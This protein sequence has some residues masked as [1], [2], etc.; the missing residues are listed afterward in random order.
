MVDDLTE[1]ARSVGLEVNANKTNWMSTNSTGQT[2]MVNGV[3]LGLGTDEIV[4]NKAGQMPKTN[5]KAYAM[6]PTCRSCAERDDSRPNQV[7]RRDSRSSKEE[8]EICEEDCGRRPGKMGS[9][10]SE[11]EARYQKAAGKTKNAK[12]TSRTST[13]LT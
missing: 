10:A 7:E 5:G 3:E 8:V 6:P 9:T 2:L 13:S 12:T 1:A 4:R 11:L